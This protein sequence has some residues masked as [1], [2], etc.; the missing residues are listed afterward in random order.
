MDIE[1]ETKNLLK[2]IEN[3]QKLVA[4]K[5]I[6]LKKFLT[7]LKKANIFL[8][9]DNEPCDPLFIRDGVEHPDMKINPFLLLQTMIDEGT[10]KFFIEKGDK[11]IYLTDL[12]VYQLLENEKENGRK[13]P[14][15]TAME[16]IRHLTLVK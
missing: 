1:T 5:D 3:I 6:T 16:N 11:R 4:I 2:S 7:K 12:E 9:I 8:E 15:K 14:E 13:T 10:T